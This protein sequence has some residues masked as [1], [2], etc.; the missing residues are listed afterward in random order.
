[1]N[2]ARVLLVVVKLRL[3]HMSLSG[4]FIIEMYESYA[5]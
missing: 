1:M 5:A 2:R 4:L 3:Q